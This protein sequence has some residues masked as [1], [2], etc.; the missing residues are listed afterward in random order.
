MNKISY[1]GATYVEVDKAKGVV[2]LDE[3][4]CSGRKNYA[5][6]SW[7][8]SPKKVTCPDCKRDMKRMGPPKKKGF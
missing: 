4:E 7:H 5:H 2:H 1:K 3:H 6:D 8:K